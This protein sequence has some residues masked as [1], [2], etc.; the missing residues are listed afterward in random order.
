M[1]S[2]E[3]I[4][5]IDDPQPTVSRIGNKVKLSQALPASP[6]EMSELTPFRMIYLP[7]GAFIHLAPKTHD[8]SLA[9]EHIPNIARLTKD[10][11]DAVQAAWHHR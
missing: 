9:G 2:T 4:K 6:T 11:N 3:T 1:E 7:M 10:L 8:I 5:L